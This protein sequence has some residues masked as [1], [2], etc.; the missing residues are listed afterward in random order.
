M[1]IRRAVLS[2]A[3][4]LLVGLA[5]LAPWGAR[6]QLV[7]GGEAVVAEVE[8]LRLKV[9]LEQATQ[10]R[11]EA[12]RRAAEAEQ[13]LS[14]LVTA[15]V[16][17]R[18]TIDLPSPSD[19]FERVAPSV[20]SV[21]AEG[22]D[23]RRG[24]GSGFAW[25]EAGH[26]VTN[27]HV[28]DGA[29][30]I[31]VAIG[32]KPWIE[33][34]LVGVS[35]AE[36]L[37]VLRIPR[38]LA[39][40]PLASAPGRPLKVGHSVY[41]IGSPHGLSGS[42][43]RGLVS[44][45]ERAITTPGGAHI[46]NAIQ[47][48]AAINPGNSGGPLLDEQGRVIGITTAILSSSGTSSGIAF[49]LPIE[50]ARAVVPGL[51]KAGGQRRLGLGLSVIETSIVGGVAL[52][53]AAVEPNGPAARAGLRA[54]SGGDVI[55]HVDGKPAASADDIASAVRRGRGQPVRLSLRRGQHPREVVLTVSELP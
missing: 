8:V 31:Y 11:F 18:R 44:G 6:A 30:Q 4:L 26:I 16:A 10:A 35:K 43:T 50:L 5:G 27:H 22:G 42:F 54:G 7:A 23:G 19:I 28:V 45:L 40:R 38:A 13:R 21:I 32:D 9:A 34:S 15:P 53:V 49:A 52:A 24:D 17:L 3:A 29:T 55:T 51:I 25:D 41:A 46:R 39:P 12:E 47:T 37:A 14:A 33:A 2:I 48:D 1:T 36:D 20:V